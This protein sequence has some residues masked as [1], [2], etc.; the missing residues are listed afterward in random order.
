MQSA[1]AVAAAATHD[2]LKLI[3]LHY[4]ASDSAIPFYR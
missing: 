1:P 3:L 2:A 4:I